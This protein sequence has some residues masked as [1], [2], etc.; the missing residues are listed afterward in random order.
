[1]GLVRGLAYAYGWALTHLPVDDLRGQVELR[2]HA[3][4]DGATAGLGVVHLAL[5]GTQKT[6]RKREEQ[7]ARER[8]NPAQNRPSS[9]TLS[10]R[11]MP[12]HNFRVY[13]HMCVTLCS[14]RRVT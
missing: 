12:I 9:S 6:H 8:T 10:A 13:A 1:M 5:L 3:E 14:R 2:D 7:V 4:R 11:Y